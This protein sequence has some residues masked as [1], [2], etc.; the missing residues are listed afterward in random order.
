MSSDPGTTSPQGDSASSSGPS[1]GSPSGG[2][3]GGGSPGGGSMGSDGGDAGQSA[4]GS[5]DASAGAGGM[6]SLGHGGDDTPD[7]SFA[8]RH[9]GYSTPQAHVGFNHDVS[10]WIGAHSIVVGSQPPIPISRAESAPRLA[11]LVVPALDREARTWGR[12]PDHLY[13]VPNVKFVVS[14]GGNL[15]YERLR[16]VMQRH[17]MV[18]SVEY[19]LELESPR[20][21]FHSW[22]Q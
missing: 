6:P 12:P 14:P 17:G 20:Q 5:V 19:R 7:N 10:V 8:T 2:A 13:W 9:W 11:A 21:T 22:V 18:S 15:T 16:P 4:S 3:P 1:A